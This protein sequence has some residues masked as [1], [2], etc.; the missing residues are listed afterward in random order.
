MSITAPPQTEK[1]EILK[2]NR[3]D[4]EA[5]LNRK[6]SLYGALLFEVAC[7]LTDP[8]LTLIAWYGEQ[9]LPSA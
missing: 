2:V 7:P 8:M 5:A 1:D 6:L 9:C 3:S 4:S